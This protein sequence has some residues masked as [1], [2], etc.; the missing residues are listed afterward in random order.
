VSSPIPSSS[1]RSLL[2]ELARSHANQ[3][4]TALWRSYELEAL[5]KHAELRGTVVDIG[6]G[7]GGLGEVVFSRMPRIERV[8]GVEPDQTD[9]TLAERS[10]RYERVIVARGDATG[11]KDASAQTVF[12]NSVFEHIPDIFPVLQEAARLLVPGGELITT[13]PSHQF[14]SCLVGAPVGRVVSRVKHTT[15]EAYVNQRLAHYHYHSPDEWSALMQRAGLE[16]VDALPYFPKPA[17]R[18]WE[19]LSDLSG[20]L[21]HALMG[22]QTHPRELQ[23]KLGLLGQGAALARPLM[24]RACVA[25]CLPWLGFETSPGVPCGG[26]LLRAVRPG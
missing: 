14:L 2:T 12:A 19:V 15:Y 21:V 23:G 20:G 6:C 4:A 13:V 1:R 3:P 16:L 11:L 25:V 17:V 10:G 8:I 5:C 24:A 18:A 7:D 26:L 9:A 22:G